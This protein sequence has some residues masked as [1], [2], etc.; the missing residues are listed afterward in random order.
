MRNGTVCH[1]AIE[2][3]GVEALVA[4]GD[5]YDVGIRIEL[6]RPAWKAIKSTCAGH[7]RSVLELLPSRLSDRRMKV[8][9]YRDNGLSPNRARS[10]WRATCPDWATMCKHAAAVLYGV[11]S[12]FEK[13]P[14][15]R[16]RL[17]G[18]DEAELIA[19]DMALPRST[20]AADTL[21]DGDL[22]YR[23]RSGAGRASAEHAEAG[24][25]YLTQ[26]G[27]PAQEE[28]AT[29]LAHRTLAR[30]ACTSPHCA[31]GRVLGRRARRVAPR[32]RGDG[33]GLGGQ[34]GTARPARLP[35]RGSD[36]AVSRDRTAGRLKA[37]CLSG[38]DRSM[39]RSRPHLRIL[40]SGGATCNGDT[41]QSARH[42]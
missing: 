33:A 7:I 4:G 3:G 23:P 21:A 40:R 10:S 24:G 8:V 12:R 14:E 31:N 26:A 1:L 34:A 42:W 6:K 39:S 25:E 27:E 36:S 11:G 22:G 32:L 19:G 20:A 13:C 41:G 38:R 17:R 35:A 5:L 9:I 29:I 28:D 18:V 2:P 30:Q 16:F 37:R 15:L